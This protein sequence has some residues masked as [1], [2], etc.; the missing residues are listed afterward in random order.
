MPRRQ[1]V[2]Y[3]EFASQLCLQ[4]EDES[5]WFEHRNRCIAAAMRVAPPTGA[6][7]DI[8]GGNGYVAA[9]IQKLGIPVV[10]LEPGR[11]AATA[12]KQRRGVETVVCATFEDAGFEPETFA[13]AGLFDVLE[14]IAD[15]IAFLT[16]VADVLR[17]NGRLYLTVPAG[18]RLWSQDDRIGGHYR[19]YTLVALCRKLHMAGFRCRYATYFFRWLPWAMLILRTIPDALG[20]FGGC[21]GA[22]FSRQHAVG[23]NDLRRAVLKLFSAEW[24]KIEQ[25]RTMGFGSSCLVVAEKRGDYR[26]SQS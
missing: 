14:H 15:D 13:S 12:A 20:W 22:R 24:R 6:V 26:G 16:K 19:R 17:D 8:G 7:L 10:L 18:P 3:P 1:I 9:M 21:T 2:S 11:S 23:S 5:F 4:V 25:G